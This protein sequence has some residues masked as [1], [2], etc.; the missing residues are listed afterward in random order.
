MRRVENCLL[1]NSRTE[2][3]YFFLKILI[4]TA[5]VLMLL[6]GAN[7]SEK[8]NPPSRIATT[9]QTTDNRQ[10]K[11][12]G[13]DQGWSSWTEGQKAPATTLTYSSWGVWERY[14]LPKSFW[15]VFY[16]SLNTYKLSTDQNFLSPVRGSAREDRPQLKNLT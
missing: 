15:G 10:Q 7:I 1:L 5:K 6:D 2:P 13:R 9:S 4:Q 14:K 16:C 12:Q 3:L 11:K 8:F